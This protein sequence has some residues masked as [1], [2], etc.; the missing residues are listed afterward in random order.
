MRRTFH[1]PHIPPMSPTP[2]TESITFLY[3]QDLQATTHFYE[4]VLG[5][6]LVV[7]QGDCRI[8]RV[9]AESFLGFCRRPSTPA[10]VQ[11]VIFTFVTNDVDAWA[12]R[13]RA[14]GIPFEKEP[15]L[16]EKYQ[17]YN[18][19]FRDPSGYLLE[20]QRFLDPHWAGA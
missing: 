10:A 16:N 17:I 9:S 12:E 7:D 2:F 18:C 1:T 19:F 14:H 15:A 6:P 13:L 8:Y 5:L 11:G 4:Q 3:T 20:I